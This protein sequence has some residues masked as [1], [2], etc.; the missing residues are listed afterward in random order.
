[1]RK[2]T[3]RI[4]N[5]IPGF[6][7]RKDRSVLISLID[8]IVP[9]IDHMYEL[10]QQVADMISIEK[11][12][13]LD[14]YER[15]GSMFNLNK[16]SYEDNETYRSRVRATVAEKYGGVPQIIKNTVAGYAGIT[17]TND[18]ENGIQVIGAWD[19]NGSIPDDVKRPG[20]FLVMIDEN[21]AT[22]N[23]RPSMLKEV[24]NSVKA[25]GVRV[26]LAV[27]FEKSFDSGVLDV[28]ER[29]W[30]S[31]K[32]ITAENVEFNIGI[33][34]SKISLL[35]D[36]HYLT[37]STLITN[38]FK[39][40]IVSTVEKFTDKVI[41]RATGDNT[42]L[43][44][45]D[46][47][48]GVCKCINNIYELP[49]VLVG[50]DQHFNGMTDDSGSDGIQTFVTDETPLMSIGQIDGTRVSATDDIPRWTL[51]Q[52]DSINISGNDISWSAFRC[53][54]IDSSSFVITDRLPPQSVC[55]NTDDD[56]GMVSGEDSTD[57]SMI[58]YPDKG[59]V[60][61]YEYTWSAYKYDDNDI[62]ITDGY[63]EL[64]DD[65]D[66]NNESN[67]EMSATDSHTATLS[68]NRVSSGIIGL[69]ESHTFNIKNRSN[70]SISL[71]GVSISQEN[72]CMNTSCVCGIGGNDEYLIAGT[73]NSMC[74][75]NDTFILNSLNI[76]SHYDI[77][78]R[79]K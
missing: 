35:N 42:H 21:L 26:Y 7:S 49:S 55:I 23:V 36:D 11:V 9:E 77:I 4:V 12:H 40:N 29:F 10:A 6:Y 54:S 20:Y 19:Y 76:N 58:M 3:N 74:K 27:T 53:D 41:Y 16:Y 34:T 32:Y 37:N 73:N 33:N 65:T 47:I 25:A 51:T 79:V 13:D 43:I 61:G 59:I 56:G 8:S 46:I 18:I 5:R 63:D 22:K 14:I 50:T 68:D 38:V 69:D 70:D 64:L 78:K 17:N 45:E 28:T 2:T 1:M 15:F 24:V 57:K 66:N 62:I 67:S 31:I 52:K 30:Q 75:L 71:S 44:M 48:D 72:I 60:G 39:L